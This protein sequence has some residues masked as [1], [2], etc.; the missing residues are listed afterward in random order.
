ML[1]LRNAVV[2]SRREAALKRYGFERELR[3]LGIFA[4]AN[5]ASYCAVCIMSDRSPSTRIERANIR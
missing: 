4:Q 3:T 1:N 5:F 2:F